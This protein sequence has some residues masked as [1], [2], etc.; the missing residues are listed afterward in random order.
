MR[1]YEGRVPAWWGRGQKAWGAKR[2]MS[3]E[4]DTERKSV[5]H[6]KIFRSQCIG[7]VDGAVSMKGKRQGSGVRT[8][9]PMIKKRTE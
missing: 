3:V 6:M 8:G 4:G 9:D 1:R 2:F 5:R 7:C